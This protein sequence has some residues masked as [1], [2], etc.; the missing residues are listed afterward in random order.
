MSPQQISLLFT[1]ENIQ[2]GQN[3][4]VHGGARSYTFMKE[5]LIFAI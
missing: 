1:P 4:P 3:Y 2:Y 5:R